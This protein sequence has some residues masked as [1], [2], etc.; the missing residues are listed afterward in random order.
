M[1]TIA[2]TFSAYHWPGTSWDIFDPFANIAAAINYGAHNGRGFGSGP[3]QIGSG[4][5]Y[6]LGGKVMDSGGWLAP[7]ATM[8]RNNTGR[9]EHLV[10]TTGRHGGDVHI[11]GDLNVRE[12]AD[13]YLIA[14]SLAFQLDA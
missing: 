1:Q 10:P 8:V 5:G 14:R 9:A 11:H 13:A 4:H 7:G 6:S 2:T 12:Q 3:G